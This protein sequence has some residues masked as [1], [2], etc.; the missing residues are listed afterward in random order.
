MN[1]RGLTLVELLA[2][3]AILGFISGIGIVAYTSIVDTG[4]NKV[5]SSYE[6]TMHAE[7]M[8][9]LSNH[10]SELPANGSHRDYKIVSDFPI[11]LIKNPRDEND[12]CPNS[13]VRVERNNVGNVDSFTYTVCLICNDYVTKT[14]NADGTISDC[15][16]FEN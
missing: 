14:K 5:Y 11:E 4:K 10:T 3:I 9:Y 8:Y 7:I 1:K 16:V 13:Y 15:R 6:E 2:V 12:T